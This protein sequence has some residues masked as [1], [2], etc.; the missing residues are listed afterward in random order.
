MNQWLHPTLMRNFLCAMSLIHHLDSNAYCKWYRPYSLVRSLVN[1]FRT[2]TGMHWMTLS[3]G[4][5]PSH[6]CASC[7]Q[8]THSPQEI[9]PRRMYRRAIGLC[10]PKSC[11]CRARMDFSYD[12]YCYAALRMRPLSWSYAQN[13]SVTTRGQ[14]WYDNFGLCNKFYALLSMRPLSISWAESCVVISCGNVDYDKSG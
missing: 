4:N 10:C 2:I 12:D 14:C 1:F 13:L 5:Q 9:P 11:I 3:N 7:A 8:A 6:Q